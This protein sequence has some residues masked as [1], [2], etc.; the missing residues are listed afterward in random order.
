MR[1]HA[2]PPCVPMVGAPRSMPRHRLRRL[3]VRS[4]RRVIRL[5]LLGLAGCDGPVTSLWP[6]FDDPSRISPR[7][8]T[9]TDDPAFVG[10]SVWQT[11]VRR[12]PGAPQ[13][14]IVPLPAVPGPYRLE[15]LPSDDA[16]VSATVKVNGETIVHPSD[17]APHPRGVFAR[18]V[19]LQATNRIEVRLTGIPG[20]TLA[21]RLLE[22]GVG[23]TDTVR[24]TNV[25]ATEGAVRYLCVDATLATTW[26]S[27]YRTSLTLQLRNVQ[28]AVPQPL[29]PS[30][31][32]S[33]SILARTGPG[34]VAVGALTVNTTGATTVVGTTTPTIGGS[35]V[36]Y[37]PFPGGPRYDGLGIQD[38]TLS[39][40]VVPPDL[41]ATA[42]WQTC[43]SGAGGV[44]F[45]VE[46]AGRWRAGELFL[47]VS[48]PSRPVGLPQPSCATGPV[49][50][51]VC[52]P[53]L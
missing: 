53:L 43:G 15:L 17:F 20:S 31:I 12:E 30:A 13:A 21:L 5:G 50:I 26:L 6:S 35:T 11:T 46:V 2:V 1:S 25:C 14:L 10:S 16:K 23:T 33:V 36:S 34:P 45:R 37:P 41:G 4:I 3:F 22:P 44:V 47:H 27:G 9:F 8:V 18:M 48:G 24:W 40:C 19:M 32:R 38:F 52:Q 7:R 39:G 28:G 29:P 42:Y 49:P 51:D